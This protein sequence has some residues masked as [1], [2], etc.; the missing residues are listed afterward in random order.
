M[1]DKNST[2]IRLPPD[3]TMDQAMA[4]TSKTFS[5]LGLVEYI[6]DAAQKRIHEISQAVS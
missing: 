1:A 5:S 6:T 3:L 2:L 4:S